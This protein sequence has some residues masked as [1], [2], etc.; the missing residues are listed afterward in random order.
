MGPPESIEQ[1]AAVTIDP[2]S[3]QESIELA[4]SLKSI[5]IHPDAPQDIERLDE[6]ADSELWA[7]RIYRHLRSLD[8]YASEKAE[9]FEGSFMV[10][11]DRSGSDYILSS[12]FVAMTESEWVQKNERARACR[13]LSS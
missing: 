13:V 4:K 12:K 9:G 7:Q 5:S 10:W 8:T 3:C 1:E 6:S 11:C 2:T